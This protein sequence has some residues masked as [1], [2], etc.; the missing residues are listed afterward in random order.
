MVDVQFD[1]D[2]RTVLQGSGTDGRCRHGAWTRSVRMVLARARFCRSPGCWKNRPLGS[3][4]IEG[5]IANRRNTIPLR[6]KTAMVFQKPLLFNRSVLD[7]A[8]S[9]PSF[10]GVSKKE[11]E[12]R[13]MVWLERFGVA[14]LCHSERSPAFWR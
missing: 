10:H 9:G 7:N 12:R 14:E 5:E 13:A 11:S 4:A 2:R 1:R 8:A 3:V 6:R